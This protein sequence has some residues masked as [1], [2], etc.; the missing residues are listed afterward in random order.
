[1]VTMM[2]RMMLSKT[3]SAPTCVS[4]TWRPR[5][6]VDLH[7]AD[8]L[9]VDKVNK[10]STRSTK[11]RQG[12]QNVDKVNKLSTRSTKCQQGQQNVDKV[13]KMSTRSTKCRQGQQNVDKVNK[14]ST[15]LPPFMALTSLKACRRPA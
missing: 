14:M 10:L 8:C 3:M 6:S 2:V 13:N 9:N 5:F 11:C 12:E 1:M 7:I 15:F 4:V